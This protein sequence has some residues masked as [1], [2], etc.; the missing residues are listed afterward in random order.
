VGISIKHDFGIYVLAILLGALMGL[1]RERKKSRLA[2]LRTFILVVL[3]GAICGQV[4]QSGGNRWILLAGTLAVTAHSTTLNFLRIQN[5]L[6]TG[7]TTAVALLVAFGIGLLVAFDQQ[8]A[9]IALSLATSVI[10]YFKPQMH[11][12][13]HN[14]TQHDLQAIFQF[15]LLAFII[16]PALPNQPYGPYNALNPYNIWLMVVMIS[17]LNLVGYVTLKLIGQRWGGPLLGVLGG[18]VSSTATTL[19]ISRHTRRYPD[20]SLTGSVVIALASTVMLVRMAFL[21]GIIHMPLL[22]ALAWPI[23]AMFVAGLVPVAFIW[24]KSTSEVAP[25]PETKNPTE[26]KQA[27]LFGLIYAVV[28]LAVSAGKDIFGQRGVYGV[29]FISGLTDVDAITLSNSR[30]AAKAVL[31]I[32]QAAVSVMIAFVS[33]LIFKLAIVGA[34]GNMKMV[35]LTM[36]CFIFLSL[37]ALLLFFI[38]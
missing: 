21:I 1:E 4:S 2:G 38:R 9:A 11:A 14:L 26:L 25:V 15:G 37:P 33:N 30:L 8:R 29:A 13:S 17:G 27:L 31:E 3:F 16:L 34:I 6:A 35:S 28:L 5:D 23:L 20:F 12:F 36:L 32:H 22:K 19:T 10:L 7:L 18:L 24:Q